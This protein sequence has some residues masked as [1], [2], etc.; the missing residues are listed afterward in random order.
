MKKLYTLIIV[1]F[2]ASQFHF[3]QAQCTPDPIIGNAPL[4]PLVL[5]FATTGVQYNQ[6]ITFRIPTD[7]SLVVGGSTVNAHID[8]TKLLYM[9]GLPPGFGKQCN[10][11]NCTF[12]GGTLGCALLSGTPD[13]TMIGSYT[14]TLYVQTFFKIGSGA[15]SPLNRIDSN[16]D[17]VFKIKSVGVYELINKNDIH[18]LKIYPNPSKGIASIEL[19][20]DMLNNYEVIVYDIFGKEVLTKHAIENTNLS[21]TIKV[22]FGELS[23]G[24]YI[25]T[26]KSQGKIGTSRLIRE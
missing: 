4:Y 3:A 18:P 19:A 6:V 23:K 12:N 20:D 7:S 10:P 8:S 1:L 13:S 24:L 25:I 15:G 21:N 17:Y 5:P 11:S 22:D 26:V 2:I 14:I 9:K 16:S